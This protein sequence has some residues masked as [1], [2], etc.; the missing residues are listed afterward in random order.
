MLNVVCKLPGLALLHICCTPDLAVHD[1]WKGHGFMYCSYPFSCWFWTYFIVWP[2][3]DG[4][5]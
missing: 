5:T 3:G 1:V 2:Y 4:N